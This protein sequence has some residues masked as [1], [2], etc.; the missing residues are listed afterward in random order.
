M[1]P[2]KSRENS[3]WSIKEYT[4]TA[5]KMLLEIESYPQRSD[6]SKNEIEKL[7]KIFTS[8]KKKHWQLI[9]WY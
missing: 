7:N 6:L 2:E 4:Q 3:E 9:H 5:H 8:L 1:E